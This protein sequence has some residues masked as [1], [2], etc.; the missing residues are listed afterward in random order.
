LLSVGTVGTGIRD[1]SAM[2]TPIAPRPRRPLAFWLLV[3]G[4]A[5]LALVLALRPLARRWAAGDQAIE[6]ERLRLGTVTRGELVHDVAAQGRVVAASR[7][8]LFSPAAG[9]VTLRVREGRQVAAGDLLAQVSSPELDSRLGQERATLAA[10]VSDVGRLELAARQQNLANEQRV[11]LDEVEVRSAEREVDRAERLAAA[12]LLNQIDLEKA[13]DGLAIQRLE[14][15]Q[16]RQRVAIER[17]MLEY[18]VRDARARADRQRLVAAD[19]ERQVAELA[20]RAPF[21]GLV[22]TVSV[23]DADAVVRGQPLIGV[24]DLSDL[25]VEIAIPETYADDVAPGVPALVRVDTVEV[26]GTLTSVAP[27][28]RNSQVAGRIAFEGGPPAGLRQNQRVSA[29]LVLDRRSGVLKVPR[30][31]FFEAGGGRQVYVVADG[32]ARRR[33]VVTGAV[34][35]TEIEIVDGLAEGEQIVLSDLGAFAGAE[36]I[37]IRD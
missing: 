37:L 10:L 36:T 27:E 34:S 22:A 35:V 12:G 9:I 26:A 28:V 11:A 20:I 21:A 14:L 1:S 29:R 33:E 25:E 4:A 30:G 17:E 19:V 31:P 24:V 6:L 5:T 32:L 7:P 16:A 3:V 18:Q 8:T 2:D 15:E 13:K 23:E